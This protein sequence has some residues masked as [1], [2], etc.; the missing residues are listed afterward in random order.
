MPQL[1]AVGFYQQ[2]FCG[3][4]SVVQHRDMEEGND[5]TGWTAGYSVIE[6]L[7][8]AECACGTACPWYEAL[9]G[10]IVGASEGVTWAN[11]E[12]AAESVS[13]HESLSFGELRDKID[14]FCHD[15]VDMVLCEDVT[16]GKC[17]DEED[18][19]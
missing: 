15:V 14:S 19:L 2:I 17:H 3:E 1:S 10:G 6:A 4:E 5:L 9:G 13:A 11:G 16:A 8:D 18:D 7:S 12:S